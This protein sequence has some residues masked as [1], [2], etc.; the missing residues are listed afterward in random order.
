VSALAH[1]AAQHNSTSH[2]TNMRNATLSSTSVS[3]TRHVP[4]VVGDHV[5]EWHDRAALL[6]IGFLT[7]PEIIS[8]MDQFIRQYSTYPRARDP[9]CVL[10]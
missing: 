6:C 7:K 9:L 1:L 4:D 10:P 8:V 3:Q 5:S 2:S